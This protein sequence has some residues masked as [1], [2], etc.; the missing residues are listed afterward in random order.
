[1]SMTEIAAPTKQPEAFQRAIR[2][3]YRWA[4]CAVTWAAFALS[5][6]D[7]LAWGNLQL[8]VGPVLDL[9]LA[10]LGI[11][12]SAFYAGY[13]LSNAVTGYVTDVFGPRLVLTMSTGLLG[14]ATAAFGFTNS[15]ALGLIFQVIMGLSAGAD[16]AAC[17]KLLTAWFAPTQRGRAIGLWFT[18]SSLA[19]VLTN[20]LVPPLSVALGWQGAYHALG[21]ATVVL[22]MVCW[23]VLRDGPQREAV[24]A[25]PDVAALL[26]DRNILLVSL[27]G[28][29]ALWG[30]WGFAFWSNALM[31]R[32]HG[33][34]P[35]DAAKILVL[36]G[37]GAAVAKPLVGLLS[38][39]LGGARK[40]LALVCLAGF[41][42][43]LLLF[44]ILRG[45]TAFWIAAP[46]LGVTAFAY[47]PLLTAL[48]AELAGRQ[49]AGS[50]SGVTNAFWQ[51]GTLLVPLA[52]GVV[53]QLTGSFL[54]AFAALA[55][56]PLLGFVA[57]LAVQESRID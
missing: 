13:V 49:A 42:A 41:V 28:F 33:I 23:I 48:V 21:G 18:A 35:S 39:W 16:Y 6:V 22:A 30:T 37:I 11:F 43:M 4:V 53:F 8:Q 46:L 55:C 36:F 20:A 1:V 44:G 56:G 26:R 19:V 27:A 54:A 52:V 10:A 31:V 47:S 25:R 24:L 51:I 15:V 3:G 50:A 29:G 32:G 14:V 12:V 17:V 38:D 45:E 40:P 5:L 34:A 7:R 2:P 9:P 57:L